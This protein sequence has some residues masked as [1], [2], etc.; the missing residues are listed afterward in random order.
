M[1][2]EGTGGQSG[3]IGQLLLTTSYRKPLHGIM[4]GSQRCL[5]G[6]KREKREGQL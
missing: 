3:V 1:S 6:K 2:I 4:A 5:S